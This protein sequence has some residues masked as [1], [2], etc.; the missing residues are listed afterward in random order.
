MATQ[1]ETPQKT[2]SPSRGQS[3]SQGEIQPLPDIVDYVKAYAR[4]KPQAAAMWCFGVGFVL[5]W[6]LKPW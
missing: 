4:Q 5:G 1:T 3:A 2:Q 6:K